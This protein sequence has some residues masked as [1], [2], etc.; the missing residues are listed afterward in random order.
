MAAT[1]DRRASD[2]ATFFAHTERGRAWLAALVPILLVAALLL[3]RLLHVVPA[4][5]SAPPG[6]S[7]AQSGSPAGLTATAADLLEAATAKGGAGYT[8]EIVQTSTISAKPDGPRIEIPDPVDVTKT[9][10]FVD[11]YLFYSLIEHGSVTPDG[12]WS[13][14]RVGPQPGERPDFDGAELRRSALVRD[15]VGWRNDRE[16]WYQAD[17]LP[18]I[19]LDAETAARLPTLLRAATSPAAKDSL[20]LDGT[21]LAVV[22]ATGKETDI[23]GLVAA[24]GAAYTKLTGPIEFGFDELGRLVRIHAV[25]LNTT[26][27]DFDLVVDTV[28]VLL[29]DPSPGPLPEPVPTWQPSPAPK[30]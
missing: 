18:G 13:E 27:T 22:D 3:S 10:G 11:E 29:Y 16:G 23:P 12:F 8:F 14:I 19:G 20:V 24:N 17:V 9:L 21:T 5:A 30:G 7:G 26:M 28:I 25:A 4:S 6:L 1:P 15:G 2:G